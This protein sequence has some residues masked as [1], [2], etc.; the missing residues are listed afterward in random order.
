VGVSRLFYLIKSMVLCDIRLR[1]ALNKSYLSF[2]RRREPSQIEALD[3]RL[4]GDDDLISASLVI[5]TF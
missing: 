2:S 4:R 3:P 1:E 5:L